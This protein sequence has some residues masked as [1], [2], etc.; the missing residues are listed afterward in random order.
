MLRKVVNLVEVLALVGVAVAVVLLFA[1]EPGA[2]SGSTA[3][4]SGAALFAANCGSC[5][6]ADGGGGLGP[7]L[8]DGAAVKRF[9]SVDDQVAFVTEGSGSMPA[10]GGRLSARQIRR[11]VDYTRTL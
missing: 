1:N 8:S 7:Q 3:P 6:G 10:F 2:G 11:V 9:P 4:S 5:H